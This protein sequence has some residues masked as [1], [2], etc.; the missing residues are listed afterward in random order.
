MRAGAQA[1]RR[2]RRTELRVR[3]NLTFSVGLVDLGPL[4]ASPADRIK[5]VLNL[6][7]I[8]RFETF[9]FQNRPQLPMRIGS[10]TIGLVKISLGKNFCLLHLNTRSPL[11]V[12]IK[13]V[14]SRDTICFGCPACKKWRKRLFL[15][16]PISTGLSGLKLELAC[17]ECI[18]KLPEA[19]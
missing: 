9:D 2:L 5:V 4:C 3:S 17:R 10:L 16:D 13:N 15:R 12:S 6:K 19:T 11:K 18:L 14:H 1:T 8:P 7:E